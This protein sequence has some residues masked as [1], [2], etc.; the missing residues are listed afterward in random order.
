M[1]LRYCKQWGEGG[2]IRYSQLYGSIS[3]KRWGN[4][5]SVEDLH[6]LFA[7]KVL[8]RWGDQEHDGYTF[9]QRFRIDKEKEG[10]WLTK[11]V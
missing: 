6:I 8:E 1:W 4:S 5:Q 11:V 9:C 2:V 3:S 10:K 7:E